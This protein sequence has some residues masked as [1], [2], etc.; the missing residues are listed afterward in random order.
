MGYFHMK[1]ALTGEEGVLADNVGDGEE[2]V[3]KQKV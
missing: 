3:T 2:S 1:T